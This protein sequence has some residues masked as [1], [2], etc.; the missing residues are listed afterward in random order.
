MSEENIQKLIGLSD[1]EQ[2]N[3]GARLSRP[4]QEIS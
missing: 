4:R 3:E 2:K 1:K